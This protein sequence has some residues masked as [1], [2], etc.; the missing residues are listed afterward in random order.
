MHGH[1]STK[2]STALHRHCVH[3]G[4]RIE[5]VAFKKAVWCKYFLGFPILI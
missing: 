4:P 1:A 5:L 2:A 3:E